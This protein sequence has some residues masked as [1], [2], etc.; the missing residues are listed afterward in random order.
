VT[1][2]VQEGDRYFIDGEKIFITN[3]GSGIHL[4]LARDA[5]TADQSKGTTKGLCPTSCREP[6][7]TASPTV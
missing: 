1:K 2:V 3:G 4:V 7:R 5:A 6:V